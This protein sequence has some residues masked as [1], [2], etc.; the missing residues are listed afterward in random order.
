MMER[1]DNPKLLMDIEWVE[2]DHLVLEAIRAGYRMNR[3]IRLGV[4]KMLDSKI[5]GGSLS[6]NDVYRPVDQALRRLRKAKKIRYQFYPT[7]WV[8]R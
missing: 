5:L 6:D 3:H 8:V 4:R 2:W 7:Q 1:R